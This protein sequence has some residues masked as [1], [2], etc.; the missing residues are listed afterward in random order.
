MTFI[1]LF[2]D[3]FGDSVDIDIVHMT[4]LMVQVHPASLVDMPETGA[5]GTTFQETPNKFPQNGAM[6]DH[7]DRL[8]QDLS[9]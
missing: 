3:L 6:G 7:V 2:G 4:D 1:Y 9:P 5:Q 8:A